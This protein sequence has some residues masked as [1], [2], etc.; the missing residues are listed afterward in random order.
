MSGDQKKQ[1]EQQPHN[2]STILRDVL[3]SD[4][5]SEYILGIIFYKNRIEKM[6]IFKI[7]S[8]NLILSELDKGNSG[9]GFLY[10][11]PN[12]KDFDMALI[13]HNTLKK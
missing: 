9:D 5:L 6:N 7:P 1:L 8:D 11:L 2:I 12:K 13:R 10:N 3:N 4:I